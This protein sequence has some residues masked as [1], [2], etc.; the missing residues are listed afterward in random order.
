MITLLVLWSTA[1]FS[2]QELSMGGQSEK[3]DTE[4]QEFFESEMAH[5]LVQLPQSETVAHRVS[6]SIVSILQSERSA[7]VDILSQESVLQ[8]FKKTV[9]KES[10]LGHLPNPKE[11][12]EDV[13]SDLERTCGD[14]GATIETIIPL[15]A[16]FGYRVIRRLKRYANAYGQ[17]YSQN[18]TNKLKSIQFGGEIR[19]MKP[20]EDVELSQLQG[21]ITENSRFARKTRVPHF[22]GRDKFIIDA[23]KE[24]SQQAILKAFGRADIPIAA[25]PSAHA[26][27]ELS[28]AY[29]LGVS[30]TDMKE[31]AFLIACYKT[32]AGHHSFHEV[33]RV[34]D[35]PPFN[36]P[37]KV[38]KYTEYMPESF[39]QTDAY[40]RLKERFQLTPWLE[41]QK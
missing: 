10:I 6:R 19:A 37:Y 35:F 23:S 34:A 26:C 13:L 41:D 11:S 32:H 20:D 7:V 24:K 8:E 39:K 18:G 12:M 3:V 30:S 1:I 17:A 25:G 5:A 9:Y 2:M 38:N 28:S 36:V 14:K 27:A 4:H 31:L 22:R 21:T 29:A 33:I 40:K 15:H 16:A